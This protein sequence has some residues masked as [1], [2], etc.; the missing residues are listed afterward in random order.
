MVKDNYFYNK[1]YIIMYSD[2]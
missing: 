1:R 2:K